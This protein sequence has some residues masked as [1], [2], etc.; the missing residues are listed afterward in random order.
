MHLK[1]AYAKKIVKPRLSFTNCF[2]TTHSQ[3]F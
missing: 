1:K 2:E 3:C